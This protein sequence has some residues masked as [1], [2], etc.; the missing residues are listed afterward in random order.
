M[1]SPIVWGQMSHSPSQQTEA[2]H[3]SR[4]ESQTHPH[5]HHKRTIYLSPIIG[6][7]LVALC[8]ILTIALVLLYVRSQRNK[9]LFNVELDLDSFS[10]SDNFLHLLWSSGPTFIMTIIVGLVL[11]PLALA[12]YRLAPYAELAKGNAR[13][14]DSILINYADLGLLRRFW[15]ATKNGK[16]PLVALAVATLLGTLLDTAASGL[17]VPTNVMVGTPSTLQ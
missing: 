11:T 3:A 9:G 12:L 17:I 7:G 2:D 16:W 15:F 8:L 5:M 14:R 4:D 6:W 13:A 10:V 1:T